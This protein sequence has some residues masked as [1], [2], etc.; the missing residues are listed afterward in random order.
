M[1]YVTDS[2]QTTQVCCFAE[3]YN[4]GG[5]D[6]LHLTLSVIDLK[7]A[8][9]PPVFWYALQSTFQIKM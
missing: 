2:L 9:A 4:Y 3:C 7:S 1:N 6:R 5:R 8:K